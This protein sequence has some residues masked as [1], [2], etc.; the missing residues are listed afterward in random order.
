MQN[1][2]VC[3]VFYNLW[4]AVLKTAAI[5][6]DQKSKPRQCNYYIITDITYFYEKSICLCVV[7]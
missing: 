6:P 1:Y 4:D 3:C 7:K 2:K 5:R